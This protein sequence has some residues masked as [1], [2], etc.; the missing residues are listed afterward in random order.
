MHLTDAYSIYWGTTE[1]PNPSR[2]STCG[3]AKIFSES[4]DVLWGCKGNY[5]GIETLAI[6]KNIIIAGQ[7]EF[8]WSRNTYKV[9]DKKHS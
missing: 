5:V 2:E 6:E 7:V 8:D 4:L 3:R 1:L 9:Y